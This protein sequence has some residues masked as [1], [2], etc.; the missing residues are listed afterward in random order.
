MREIKFRFWDTVE[1]KW[2]VDGRAETSI[3]DF[4]F[5]KNMNWRFLTKA[6][7]KDRV[8]V[9]QFTGLKDKNGKEIWEGDIVK[10][11]TNDK[12]WER[13]VIEFQVHTYNAGFYPS[14]PTNASCYWEVIGNIHESPE[15]LETK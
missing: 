1:K 9:G 6:Q 8:V 14:K 13:V 2:M 15:L 7:A 4:A 3:Y 5:K 10:F 12:D 11:S